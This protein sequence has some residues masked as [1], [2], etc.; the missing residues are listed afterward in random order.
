MYL[1][2]YRVANFWSKLSQ[3]ECCTIISDFCV[4]QL[5]TPLVMYFPGQS[6]DNP[7]LGLVC[8]S[9]KHK[10]RCSSLLSGN[11]FLNIKKKNK[12]NVQN[13][14][15]LSL[16]KIENPSFIESYD[17]YIILHKQ[18]VRLWASSLWALDL[19]LWMWSFCN[20]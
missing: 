3:T 15:D 7:Q 1:L 12:T 4:V 18:I 14:L 16:W 11:N 20:L 8:T 10:Q 6:T 5:V 9:T 19:L 2:L 17:V 13:I